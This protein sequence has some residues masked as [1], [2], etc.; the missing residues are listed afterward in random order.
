M[1]RKNWLFCDSVK[2]A[3]SSAIVY[4][5]VETAKVNGLESYKYLRY[6]LEELPY[7]EKS[8]AYKDLEALMPWDPYIHISCRNARFEM[9]RNHLSN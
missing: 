3:Q 4:S 9:G 2:G 5:L 8:P 7:L 6:I 1:G